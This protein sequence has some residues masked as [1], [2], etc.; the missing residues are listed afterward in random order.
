MLAGFLLL[1]ISAAFTPAYAASTAKTPTATWHTFHDPVYGF[2]LQYPSTWTLTPESDGSHITLLNPIT[3]TTV[4]PIVTTQAG[5]ASA[6]LK[7][8]PLAHSIQ[9]QMRTIAGHPAT[10]Y[11]LPYVAASQPHTNNTVDVGGPQQIRQVI[12]PVSNT[13]G[14]TNVY[15]FQLTQPTSKTGKISAAEQ[16]DL[17]TFDAILKSF[18]LPTKVVSTNVKTAS[19]AAA[20]CDRICWADANVDYTDYTDAHTVPNSDGTY[21]QPNFQCAEFVARA[22]TQDGML[23]GLKNGGVNGSDRK[24]TRL[25][26][27]H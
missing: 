7:K 14:T 16:A 26:S 19:A 21:T 23:P 10:D 5:A 1:S 3:R 17:L 24:S 12:V 4:S 8:T 15:T 18:T 22:I 20:G 9:Q 2:S 11:L 13:S 27:S 6:V 25:N